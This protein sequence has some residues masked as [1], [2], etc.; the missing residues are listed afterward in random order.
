MDNTALPHHSVCCLVGFWSFTSLFRNKD[1][2]SN[3]LINRST[4]M[5]SR[6]PQPCSASSQ[7]IPISQ[8]LCKHPPLWCSHFSC[9]LVSISGPVLQFCYSP[10]NA[11]G[12]TTLVFSFSEW[13]L[14]SPFLSFLVFFISYLVLPCDTKDSSLPLVMSCF[15]LLHVGNCHGPCLCTIQ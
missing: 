7:S 5:D 11:H 12:P 10:F 8:D 1:D 4:N 13:S 3:G 14:V 6:D 9:L 2:I 15:Q